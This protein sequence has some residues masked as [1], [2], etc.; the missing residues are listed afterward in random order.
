MLKKLKDKFMKIVLSLTTILT[1]LCS[2]NIPIRAA[3]VSSGQYTGYSVTSKNANGYWVTNSNVQQILIDGEVGFC[4]E[5]GILLNEGSGF[6]PSSYN[7]TNLSIIAYEGWVRSS[8]TMKDYLAT[9]FMIWEAVGGTITATSFSDYASYKSKIQDRINKHSVLPS[10]D[11]TNITLKIG[12]K[13]T[14]TDTNGVFNQFNFVSSNGLSVS[15]SGN[16]LTI[17][18]T[19]TAPDN[20]TISYNKIPSSFVGTSIIYKKAGSQSVARFF[21]KDPLKTDIYVKVLKYGTLKLAKQ[22][23]LG[24]MVPNTT[25]KTSYNAD[26]SGSTWTYT[27]GEDGTVTIPNWEPKTVYIQEVS[28]PENLVLDPTIH[29]IKIKPNETVT[30]TQTN[31]TQKGEITLKKVDAETSTAQGDATL[32]G[33]VYGLY[34]KED[35]VNPISG[36]VL[37]TKDTKVTEVKTDANGVAT[38]KDLDLGK[39][40]VK[41]ITSSNGYHLDPTSYDVELKYAGQTETIASASLQVSE[42]VLKFKVKKVQENNNAT[43]PNTKFTHVNQNGES[44]EL[45]TNENGEFTLIGLNKGKHSLMETYVID[46]LLINKTKVEFNVLENGKIEILT[47]LKDTGITFEFDDNKN[48]VLVVR[49]EAAPFSLKLTKTNDHDKLLDGA[50]F[51]L[52]SDEQCTKVLDTQVSKNGTL[53]FKGLK[54]RT[55][56]FFKETKAPDGYRIPLDNTTQKP[57]VY[58]LYVES[59]PSKNIFDYFVDGVKYTLDKN[60][61]NDAIHV[62]GNAANRVVSVRIVNMVGVQLPVTGSY[63]MYPLML[64]GVGLMSLGFIKTRMKHKENKET[65]N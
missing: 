23:E 56:Y 8:R 18:A 45:R 11:K 48:G 5:P 13:T 16:S 52:Y 34:A 58:S 6:T 26:M 44:K 28:V 59:T 41:E 20:A 61:V 33:A 27:T 60:N 53:E 12:E 40:Y 2:A 3:T 49:D 50:E 19:A 21:V 35:I 32:E 54:D 10:F 64:T 37:I 31:Q 43:V 29:S 62:E 22:N 57:H 25:F 51:T 30:Y 38:F 42:N 14:L 9:Q 65:H 15:K 46:G 17:T 63:L 55:H 36:N 39:Y 24:E 47:N 4:T 7:Q 1:I